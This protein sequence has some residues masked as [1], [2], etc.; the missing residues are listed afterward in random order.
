MASTIVG[1]FLWSGLSYAAMTSTNWEIRWDT[2][3]NGGSE[4]STSASYQLRDTLGNSAIGQGSST[5]YDLRGG[6]RQGVFDQI[7]T[8]DVM[9]SQLS[10][11]RTVSASVGTT[12]TTDTAGLSSGDYVALVQNL[13]ASQVTAIGR[14]ASV[15]VGTITVDS[16]SDGGVAPVIDGTN[17]YLYKL[18]GSTLDLDELDPAQVNT[19]IV[20]FEVSADLENGYVVQVLEDGNLRDG[21]ETINDVADGT[22]SVGSEE[23]GGRS[24][25]TTLSG[26]TFDTSDTAFT[27]SFQDV[28]DTANSAFISRNFLTLKASISGTTVDGTYGHT[29]TLIVSGNF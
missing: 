8:F 29:L 16:L 9:N 27:S 6:Y 7:L 22:V 21:A 12:I 10:S 2:I 23:Y 20:G 24:S 3:G 4:D 15:G 5:S 25:D 13:G 14:I 26:S 17:D 18:A 19:G 28:A 1:I 11:K